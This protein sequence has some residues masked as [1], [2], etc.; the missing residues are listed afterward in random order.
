MSYTTIANSTAQQPA[1]PA[2]H[3]HQRKSTQC[4]RR[5]SQILIIQIASSIA[6]ASGSSG[7]ESSA[8]LPDAFKPYTPLR[9]ARDQFLLLGLSLEEEE[10]EEGEIV[11]VDVL[12]EGEILE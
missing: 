6:K 9:F 2:Q 1:A 7:N 4:H 12:E 3:P 8:H 10:Y 5:G 11:E